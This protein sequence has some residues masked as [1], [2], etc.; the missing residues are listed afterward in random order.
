MDSSIIIAVGGTLAGTIV[1]AIGT[2]LL[3]TRVSARQRKWAL[4][5]DTRNKER[6]RE[7]EQP[8]VKRE[9]L[10]KRLDV[11][12]EAMQIMMNRVRRTFSRELGGVVYEGK[13]TIED[14]GRR[15]QTIRG[16]A[17]ASVI[18]TSS[19]DLMEDWKAIS[20]A[21][22]EVEETGTLSHERWDK[23]Q[24]AYVEIV[25]LTDEM[26]AEI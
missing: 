25:K 14:E 11:M 17:W 18:A 9:L 15:L 22:G 13:T 19:K 16:E 4:E 12:E 10:S 2:Y 8:R 3:Q 21:H 24:K 6:E 23:A 5:D 26:K 7:A 20:Q 1:S